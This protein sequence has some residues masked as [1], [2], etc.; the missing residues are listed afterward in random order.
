MLS[1]TSLQIIGK[2]SFSTITPLFNEAK[3]PSSFLLDKTIDGFAD[4]TKTS[5]NTNIARQFQ[6]N[7]PIGTTY[8]P[9]D[10]SMAKIHLEKKKLREKRLQ[11]NGFDRKNLN[12]LDFYTTPRYLS[13]YLSNTGKILN[14]EV[15]GLSNKN[16]KRLTV[17]IKRAINAG[18]L[19]PVHKDVGL[20]PH[21]YGN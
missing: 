11:T 6:T 1:K 5:E 7:F 2:R 12:P 9:F 4:T 13:A 21:R 19:S 20:L 16:Q 10:F 3:S 14:R 15:T 8:D 18:L 17:A